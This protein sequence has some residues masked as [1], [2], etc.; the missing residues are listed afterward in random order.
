MEVLLPY[1]GPLA[2]APRSRC[3]R[4]SRSRRR[5]E[6]V[7]ASQRRACGHSDG[8][9]VGDHDERGKS[10][11]CAG[12]FAKVCRCCS[13]L[14]KHDDLRTL[15]SS[16]LRYSRVLRHQPEVFRGAGIARLLLPSNPP[17]RSRWR[18]RRRRRLLL[19][20]RLSLASH[21][22]IRLQWPPR[23]PPSGL[24]EAA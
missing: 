17:S 23:T 5:R 2:G 16:S 8:S 1:R 10:P 19:D 18:R 3:W 4:C 9:G 15:L 24:R 6:G 14:P 12:S 21:R 13:H 7:C 22:G 20:R 11:P